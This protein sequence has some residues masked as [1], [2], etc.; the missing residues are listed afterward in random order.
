[1]GDIYRLT[2]TE[3]NKLNKLLEA[4]LDH[5]NEHGVVVTEKEADDAK[6]SGRPHFGRYVSDADDAKVAEQIR[7]WSGHD[8]IHIEHVKG[9]RRALFGN[10]YKPPTEKKKYYTSVVTF[11]EQVEERLEAFEKRIKQVEF[12]VSKQKL[13]GEWNIKR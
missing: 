9:Q 3:V 1:M 12:E 10:M 7:T 5:V 13:A 6:R 8:R 2:K 11:K 4:A